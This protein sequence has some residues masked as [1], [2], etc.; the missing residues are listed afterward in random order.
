VLP[1]RLILQKGPFPHFGRWQFRE[2]EWRQETEEAAWA[3]RRHTASINY[4]VK[5]KLN[6]TPNNASCW[7]SADGDGDGNGDGDAVDADA[8]PP[9]FSCK[10]IWSRSSGSPALSAGFKLPVSQGSCPGLYI[11]FPC[12]RLM[13]LG[14]RRRS[15]APSVFARC[16]SL[17]R[18]F[19]P[20]LSR[21]WKPIIVILSLNCSSVLGAELLRGCYGGGSPSLL[22]GF[23]WNLIN[24]NSLRIH[25]S[26]TH[27]GLQ[28][29]WTLCCLAPA[30]I[31]IFVLHLLPYSSGKC[32]LKT[33]LL[34][35][36][37]G[38]R[39]FDILAGDVSII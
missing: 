36:H 10:R 39:K 6:S 26:R 9:A 28:F 21:Q 37:Y 17:C 30:L 31:V 2:G 7:V 1:P 18:T 11:A 4:K 24:G 25:N 29:N 38:C 23:D 33:P 19:L 8:S 34:C 5:L 12:W 27:V 22:I 14:R 35:M 15:T 20:L 32:P 16:H 13:Q 3:R